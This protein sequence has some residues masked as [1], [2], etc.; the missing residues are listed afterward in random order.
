M[1]S[2]AKCAR[3]RAGREEM[4][5]LAAD[6]FVRTLAKRE[7][8][9]LPHIDLTHRSHIIAGCMMSKKGKYTQICNDKI[10]FLQIT[11]EKLA[12]F[13]FSMTNLTGNSVNLS[14]IYLDLMFLEYF[15]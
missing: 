9:T 8:N 13:S 2:S 14:R 5:T 1:T 10:I 15:F 11:E 7:V 3:K 4:V 12:W 6:H